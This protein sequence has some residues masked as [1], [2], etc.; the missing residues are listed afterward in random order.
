MDPV[1][2]S[3]GKGCGFPGRLA[4]AW[5]I[6]GKVSSD[7]TRIFI[8]FDEKDGS[9]E[10]FDGFFDGER[11]GLL[12]PDGTLW[13]KLGPYATTSPIPGDYNDSSHPGCIRRVLS[14]G[15]V[16]GEDPPGLL[17]PGSKCVPGDITTPWELEGSIV[18][19]QLVV[20]FDPIDEVK[21]G[22][23]LAQFKDNTLRTANGL[24]T[25]KIAP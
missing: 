23:I 3:R 7:D 1:P 9:G 19:N 17:T 6:Q 5:K 16:Q 2:F 11:N 25:K 10:A 22:P 14:S 4:S 8:N 13:K 18:G 24:W 12:L 21:Q 15:N 20:S